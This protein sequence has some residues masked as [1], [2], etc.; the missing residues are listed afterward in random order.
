MKPEKSK[1]Q[2]AVFLLSAD[3]RTKAGIHPQPKSMKVMYVD[4]CHLD[5]IE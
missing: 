4:N 5:F 2:E 3:D 1:R